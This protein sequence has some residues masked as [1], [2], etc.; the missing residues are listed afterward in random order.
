V[1][2]CLDGLACDDAVLA[3]T[4]PANIDLLRQQLGDALGNVEFIRVPPP[5]CI[6]PCKG[7]IGMRAAVAVPWDRRQSMDS[8][9]VR[10]RR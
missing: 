10:A 1:P 7:Y 3:V 6:S 2:F 4:T 5:A 8:L 9:V